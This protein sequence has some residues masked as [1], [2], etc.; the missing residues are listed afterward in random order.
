MDVL[1]SIYINTL[2]S[3]LAFWCWIY[4]YMSWCNRNPRSSS[5]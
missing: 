2:L 1:I 3:C 4:S 5:L